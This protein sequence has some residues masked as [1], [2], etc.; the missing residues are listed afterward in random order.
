MLT[1]YS[2]A[3]PIIS[4]DNTL[5]WNYYSEMG[6][7]MSNRLFEGEKKEDHNNYLSFGKSKY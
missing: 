5:L 7:I 1:R 3:D 6:I 4:T 2:A